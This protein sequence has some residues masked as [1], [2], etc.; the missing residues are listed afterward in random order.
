MRRVTRRQ[1]IIMMRDTPD[2][3]VIEVLPEESYRQ[4]HL[5]GALNAPLEDDFETRIQQAAPR[6]DE[7]IVIYSRDERSDATPEAVRRMQA[8]GYTN[9]Y[10]YAA[11][12]T[13]WKGAGLLTD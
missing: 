13:D 8:L 3:R 12:K 7:P 10:A 6:K 4:F 5:P 1:M 11:G 2:L 9:V